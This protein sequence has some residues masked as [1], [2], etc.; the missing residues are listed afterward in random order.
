MS[1][2]VIGGAGYIGSHC[3]KLLSKNKIKH[4][5]LDNLSTGFEKNVK[6]GNFYHGDLADK[7]LLK[8]IFEKEKIDTVM[9]FAALS[10]VGD[11]VKYPSKYYNNNVSKVIDLLEQMIESNIKNFIFSSTCA[12]YGVPETEI[13]TEEHKQEPINPYGK[14]KLMVEKTLEDYDHAYG[15]KSV[16]FRYFNAAGADPDSEI[17]EEHSPETHLIPLVLKTA[18]GKRNEISIFGDDYPTKD[19]TCIRDYI[20]VNDLSEAH[21]LGIKFLKSEKRSEQFNLGNGHGFS[22]KEIIDISE[23][24]TN[25]KINTKIVGRRDGDPAKLIGSSDK[26][27]SVLSWKAKH[28]DIE[29]I[30]RSAWNFEVKNNE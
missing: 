25:R 12:T 27:R 23:M 6:W 11:S 10:I 4:A 9:H 8:E 13:L 7:N 16:A 19:G 30:I 20:H 17:G 24:I 1:V 21:I 15:L 29:N 28:T 2:L 18:I 5:V 3:C 14:S 22:V 26:A